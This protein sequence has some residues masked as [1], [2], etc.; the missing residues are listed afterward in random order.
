MNWSLLLPGYL[1]TG[2]AFGAFTLD[3]IVPR[4][5]RA[6][7]VYAGAAALAVVAAVILVTQDGAVH[8]FAGGILIF[9]SYSYFFFALFVVLAAVT[10]LGSSR[11]VTSIDSPGEFVAL[12]MMSAVGAMGM[13]AAGELITAYISLELLSF[14]LYILASYTWRERRTNEAGTKYILLGALASAFLLLGIT[15][16]YGLT[17]D[18]RYDRVAQG[19]AAAETSPGLI[20]ALAMLT[21]GL[22]FKVAAV[23]F[24]MWTPDV[25]EGAPIPITAYLAAASKAAGFALL[26]RLVAVALEP[27]VLFWDW[28]FILL[29]VLSMMLGNLVAILQSNLKRL[30]AYSSIGQVGYLLLG[31]AAL[32][33]ADPAKPAAGMLIHIVSYAAS[34]MVAF[35]VLLAVQ[36]QT[37]REGVRDMAGL[38]RRNPYLAMALTAALFSLAGFP[39]FI[40]FASKFYLFTVVAT[41]GARFLVPVGLAIF[42]SLISLYYYLNIVRQMYIEP[43][44]DNAPPLRVPRT[45]W[46]LIAGLLGVIVIGGVYVRPLAEAAETAAAA[47]FTGA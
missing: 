11:F 30:M 6:F 10:I 45:M 13:A 44:Q 34:T 9:D 47:I 26:I 21:A 8:R 14:S 43:P 40:G 16:I 41:A 17:G 39:F 28:I 36:Q 7:L 27:V 5:S 15:Y 1:V 3:L 18:T 4:L 24:H 19:L 32:G 38:A 37:G 23:P 12:L 31:I 20:I 46:L 33:A 25:Y 22:G 35:M 42:A 2:L 29:A